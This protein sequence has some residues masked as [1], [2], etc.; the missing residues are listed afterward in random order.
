[1]ELRGKII[2]I[3]PEQSG[4]AKSGNPWRVQPYVLETL[5]QYPRKVYFEVFGD[6]RIKNI[7]VKTGDEVVVSF[8]IESRE[9]NGR[10]YTVVRA[11]RVVSADLAD[12]APSEDANNPAEEADAIPADTTFDNSGDGDLPF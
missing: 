4:V 11:W 8:D 9:F 1:M 5:D 6:E 2:Q 7:N 12:K 3:L 10:Y